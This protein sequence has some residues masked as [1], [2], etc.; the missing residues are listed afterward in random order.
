MGRWGSVASS[1][2]QGWGVKKLL[3]TSAQA[4]RQLLARLAVSWSSEETGV[5]SCGLCSFKTWRR[6]SGGG[7]TEGGKMPTRRFL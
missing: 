4:W 5:F 2:L 3:E 1:F 7:A 6:N